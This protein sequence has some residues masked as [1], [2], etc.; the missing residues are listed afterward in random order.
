MFLYMEFIFCYKVATESELFALRE[1][2]RKKYPSL[3]DPAPCTLDIWNRLCLSFNESV[4]FQES[5]QEC[6]IFRGRHL[7]LC[8]Y[9]NIRN[10]IGT[11]KT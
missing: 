10:I 11:G 8:K 5:L 1:S 9:P 6:G 3:A 2:D 7:S 4:P